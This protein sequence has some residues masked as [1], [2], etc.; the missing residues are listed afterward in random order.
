MESR[1]ELER[2]ALLHMPWNEHG[3]SR[4]SLDRAQRPALAET[5]Y[6]R[7]ERN[8]YYSTT[9]SNGIAYYYTSSIRMERV[10]HQMGHPHANTLA[11]DPGSEVC[12][13]VHVWGERREGSR[14]QHNTPAPNYQGGDAVG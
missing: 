6:A 4:A 7:D 14:R 11:P 12:D 1:P 13:R 9:N 5:N 3:Y 2:E 8:S 10:F